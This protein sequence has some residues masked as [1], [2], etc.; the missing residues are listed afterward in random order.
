MTIVNTSPLPQRLRYEKSSPIYSTT[1][2]KKFNNKIQSRRT[3]PKEVKT[4]AQSL[5]KSSIQSTTCSTTA[6]QT[7]A[8][9]RF[10]SVQ[11]SNWSNWS[12]NHWLE[13][14]VLVIQDSHKVSS[15]GVNRNG[16]ESCEIPKFQCWQTWCR[17]KLNDHTHLFCFADIPFVT[18]RCLL[19]VER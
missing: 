16:M 6:S 14:R 13:F 1:I 3:S 7:Q 19:L 18:D 5:L 11:A 17:M 4:V 9:P 2:I 12:I 8:T 10:S 15:V